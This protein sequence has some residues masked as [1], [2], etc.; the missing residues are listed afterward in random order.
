MSGS[1]FL[2]SLALPRFSRSCLVIWANSALSRILEAIC[3]SFSGVIAASTGPTVVD[4][5]V[6]VR[7]DGLILFYTGVE[8]SCLITRVCP[9]KK[10]KVD[11]LD[12]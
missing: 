4:V 7:C 11:E 1:P 3:C 12:S 9:I 5:E 10:A 6:K 8:V 2:F